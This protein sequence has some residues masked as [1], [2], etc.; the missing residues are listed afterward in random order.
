[1]SGA[2]SLGFK[3]LA[4]GVRKQNKL[5]ATSDRPDTTNESLLR[6]VQKTTPMQVQQVAMLRTK[7]TKHLKRGAKIVQGQGSASSDQ[8]PT[9]FDP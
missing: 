4:D 6:A 8:M 9:V 7:A 5:P 3:L 2:N 1:M